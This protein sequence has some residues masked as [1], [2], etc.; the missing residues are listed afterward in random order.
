MSHQMMTA[1]RPYLWRRSEINLF[2]VGTPKGTLLT[3][4]PRLSWRRSETISIERVDE[5]RGSMHVRQPASD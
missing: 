2:N 3:L 5:Q 1:S 4:T